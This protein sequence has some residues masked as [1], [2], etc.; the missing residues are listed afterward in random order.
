MSPSAPRALAALAAALALTSCGGS[1][2]ARPLAT[3]A[4][5]L[6]YTIITTVGLGGGTVVC[7]P[8]PV[9]EGGSATCAITPDP[10]HHVVDV[11]V[12]GVSQGPITS[13]PFANVV[14]A[15]TL[16]ATF[17]ID[18]FTVTPS[19]G[20]NGSISPST[21]QTVNHGGSVG[22]TIAPVANHQVADVLVDGSSV[23]AVTSYTFTNVTANHTIAASFAISTYTIAPSAGA[24]GSISPATTQT[25]SHGGSATFT[26]TPDTGYHVADVLVDGGSVGAVTSYT[27]SGVT[28]NHTIAATFAINTYTITPSAGANGSISPATV[29]TV[30]HG[31]SAT[32]TFTP[33]TGYHVASVTVDGSAVAVASSYAFTNVSANHTIAVAFAIDTF[34]ITASAGANGSISPSGAVGVS[35]GG[36]QTF[37]FTPATGCHVA[38]VTVDGASVAVAPSYAFTNVTANHTISASFAINTYTI[39]PSAGA[40]GSISPST[41]QTVDH[42]SSAAFIFTPT[43]GYHVASV[44]VDGAAVAIASSYAFTNVT[45]NHTIA[46]TFAI[47]TFTITASAG[48]N[49]SISP[50]GAVGVSYGGNQTFT[51]TPTT[52]Y[53]VATVT[54]D[55]SAV[56]V[57]SSYA[58]TNVTANR[59]IAVTFAI[60]TFTITASAGAN[61]S[62]SPSGAVGVSYGGNQ[63]FTFTPATG[64]H[65][66]A[67]TVDGSAVA[68]ASSYAFT[69]VTANH[70]I[71]ASFAINTYTITPSAGANGSISPAT[72]QTVDHGSSAT[73]TFTPATG[74]HVASITVDGAGV[75]VAP[76]Y[77]F[78]NVTANHSIA[79]TFALDTF[80]ITASAGANGSISP[81]GAVGVSYGGNPTFTFTP[82]TGYHVATIT[83]DGAAVAV[84]SSYAFTNVTANHSIAVTFALDTFTITASA[85]ANGSISPSGAVG[86]SYGGTQTFTFTPATGYHV[87]TVTVDGSAVAVPSSYAFTNVTA[88]HSIVVTFAIDTFTITASAGP[89]GSISPSGA[90]PVN[91]GAAQVFT[92]TPAGGYHVADVLVDG[93]SIGA[94]TSY[95][96]T[97]VTSAH[98]ITVSFAIN[99]YTITPSVT[100]ANGTISPSTAQMVN[101][102]SSATFTFTPSTGYHVASVTVD[103]VAAAVGPS[104]TFTA[105]AANHSIAVSFAIDTFTLTPSAGAN[106]AIA[107][108]T[109]QIVSYGGSLTFTITPA[110]GHH[111]ATLTVD[112][113]A[114]AIA[115]SYTFTNVT[116]SHTLAATFAIDTFTITASAGAN[117]AIAPSGAVI[118]NHGASQAFTLTPAAGYR[119]ATLTVDGTAVAAATGYTFTNVTASHT[120]AGT[121][122]KANGTACAAAAECGSGLC[123]DGVCCDLACGGQCQ[124]CDV[125]GKGGT[126][127]AVTGAPHGTRAACVTDGTTCGGSCDGTLATAC[128][129][130]TSSCR[131]ASCAA[132]VATLAAAC[133][134]AGRCPAL[135][136]V[137]CAPFTCGPT[138]CAGDCTVD[139]NC[140]TSAYCAA[141][142]CTPKKVAGLACG[143]ANQC[144][145]GFCVDG[146]CCNG[147]CDRQCQACD[148]AGK[149]G[150]CSAVTGAPHGARAACASDGSTC[151][152]ACDGSVTTACAFPTSTCRAA[153]CADGTATIAAA[154]DGA[155]H[156][157]AV[158]T[159]ACAPYVCGP[160]ACAG[161]CTGDDACVS[162][163]FCGGGVC[164]PKL[165]LGLACGRDGEC[166]GG[167]CVDGVCC[168]GVC[169]GQ[170]EACNLQGQLGA[171]K[172]VA[173]A[174]HG[175]RPACASDGT[176]C[177][178][179]CDATLRTACAFPG[180]LT[181]CRDASC[182]GG[183]ATLA[184]VCDGAGHC[185]AVETRLCEPYVCGPTACA[186]DCAGDAHCVE[187]DWCSAGVCAPR[188]ADG[189]GCGVANACASGIC[190]AGTCCHSDCP[191]PDQAC[192]LPGHQG[193]CTA[194][195]AVGCRADA[196][197]PSDAFCLAG[198]CHPRDDGAA[199]RVGGSGGCA[200]TGA[201]DAAPP[202]LALLALLGLRRRRRAGQALL[203]VAGLALAGAASAQTAAQGGF[204][205]DRFQPRFGAA[206]V[207]AVESPSVPG[208]HLQVG[209][210]LWLDFA[211]R[212]LRLWAKD[213]ASYEVALVSN[214]AV[215]N[216]GASVALRGR[217]ELA[218]AIPATLAQSGERTAAF[219]GLPEPTSGAA[220]S[221]V[222]L[223]GKARLWRLGPVTLG[224]GLALSLPTGSGAYRAA[225]GPTAGATALA[226]WTRGRLRVLGNAGVVGR[227][228]QQLLDL[229]V[230][231]AVALAAAAEWRF[232]P[233]LSGLA[234]L[235]AEAGLGGGG[236]AWPA[237]AQ[238]AL[239][240]DGPR[241]LVLTAGAGAGLTSGFGAPR[242]RGLAA[243]AFSPAW[244][245]P[246]DPDEIVALPAPA[247]PEA[248]PPPAP[249]PGPPPS[250]VAPP[251]HPL[252]LTHIDPPRPSPGVK[253]LLHG[254]RIVLFEQVQFAPG[255]EALLPASG[256]LLRQVAQILKDNPQIRFV[257]IEGHTDDSGELVANERLS[258][259]RAEKVRDFLVG[260]GVAAGRLEPRGFGPTRPIAPNDTSE[261]RAQNRRVEFVILETSR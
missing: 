106:G 185:P 235:N 200:S 195:A 36:N 87:A 158:Q 99:T 21:V 205:V 193:T 4:Q 240:W 30:D 12:D 249:V 105:V 94:V 224:A 46:V 179:A 136:T 261:G 24:N 42:G 58:F 56:A 165:Q 133:D 20:P 181:S 90:V 189:A 102:G 113:V 123:V 228:K 31:S 150:T 149:V 95:T 154:C 51:F 255:R 184:A 225:T 256:E 130:P 217:Y 63:T 13:Y 48:A 148:V 169:D 214:Q 226:E 191:G 114:V 252:D 135:Q 9:P 199:F 88:N 208:T 62:I 85:G 244:P 91:Y 83:V 134:G 119:V 220:L 60:D 118:V 180:A 84:A 137:T 25:V 104:Y 187:G 32:F 82:A 34:T 41:V 111:V 243:I 29:Q 47:D 6:D 164:R 86:V 170:C 253:A 254:W 209:A 28:A 204:V 232:S 186:G 5:A 70:T 98:T 245:R 163:S 101:H 43:T 146:V 125:A 251:E 222:R 64:Y 138:A 77:A 246:R 121:F 2:P 127:S 37:T 202:V 212:P 248:G 89:N 15:H 75:A 73:F 22:F 131:T 227:R 152:G 97:L 250:A 139:A 103:G 45:A 259:R 156:C 223:S 140:S 66:A 18:T 142:V 258:Q 166:A 53:H 96:F 210:G 216:L 172:A 126:C 182:D 72:V 178:G 201:S 161:G 93:F 206:D 132:G 151:G 153:S 68:V 7:T 197:C 59:T 3:E 128:T 213:A 1:G 241:G 155:G 44:L 108:A 145:S 52:G 221:D 92:F 65:V 109:A 192:N 26:L 110:T 176:L 74:Y 67:V 122:T 40:N 39:T 171:C 79:V 238:L 237:E 218:L 100:G 61:G 194:L 17:A 49:G 215:A 55:G 257:Q 177:G 50:S 129:Y 11:V 175:G 247:A 196:D 229:T 71:S 16:D 188:G 143:G 27:F 198:A 190:V 116:A 207:L 203:A 230:S 10:A 242:W 160:T 159:V 8:N 236:A 167:R 117:G 80:T 144:S 239:R 162:T 78:T 124:A 211:D 233:A 35:Y 234:A 174:P 231:S 38:S 115:S 141:G 54:V 157:P 23:G 120:I 219:T 168:D 33:T 260:V 107:P 19:A 14:A 183:V 112:G 173:G 76:S 147:T 81:S 57:A 69:N